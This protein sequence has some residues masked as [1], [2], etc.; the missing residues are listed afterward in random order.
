MSFCKKIAFSVKG[1]GYPQKDAMPSFFP[2]S[3]S[4]IYWLSDDAIF[5]SELFV[6]KIA[7]ESRNLIKQS[8]W[9]AKFAG[10]SCMYLKSVATCK[11]ANIHSSRL[12]KE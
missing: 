11:P 6:H 4:S 2:D 5:F 10:P 1:S 8:T 3:K 12:S 7:E 9:G